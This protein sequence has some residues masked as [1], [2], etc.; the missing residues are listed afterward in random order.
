MRYGPDFARERPTT[1]EIRRAIQHSEESLRAF[2]NR[3]GINQ[4][5][6]AKWKKRAPVADLLIEPQDHRSSVLSLD[7]ERSSSLSASTCSCL[8]MAASIR[9][10][11][12]IPH[13]TRSS[14]QRPRQWS[15]PVV[16]H[17]SDGDNY[18][19]CL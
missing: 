13:L 18:P 7:E 5:T 16:R 14:V 15:I 17:P 12:T 1:E 10:Q 6:V 8:R 9:L 4:K 19:G 2:S 11:L 3:Y